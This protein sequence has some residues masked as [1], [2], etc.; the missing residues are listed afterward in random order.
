MPL[1]SGKSEQH[2]SD[3]CAQAG[4]DCK[5]LGKKRLPCTMNDYLIAPLTIVIKM[6]RPSRAFEIYSLCYD[7]LLF[8]RLV[9]LLNSFA[10]YDAN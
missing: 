3:I 9:D 10:L 6:Q 4:Q 7:K 2:E 5:A 8:A 1:L